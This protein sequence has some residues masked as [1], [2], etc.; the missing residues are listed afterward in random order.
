LFK[1][2]KS[3]AFDEHGPCPYINFFGENKIRKQ[4]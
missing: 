4:E 3:I 1:F 2:P